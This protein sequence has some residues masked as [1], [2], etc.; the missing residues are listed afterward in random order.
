MP[1][2]E[3]ESSSELD[4]ASKLSSARSSRADVILSN[5]GPPLQIATESANACGGNLSNI[6][7][8]TSPARKSREQIRR[9]KLPGLEEL[10]D[11]NPSAAFQPDS[12]PLSPTTSDPASVSD[13]H[14]AQ[15]EADHGTEAAQAVAMEAFDLES[16]GTTMSSGSLSEEDPPEANP[17]GGGMSGEVQPIGSRKAA[18]GREAACLPEIARV[19]TLEQDMSAIA[20]P[21]AMSILTPTNDLTNKPAKPASNSSSADVA[22]S[23]HVRS[24]ESLERQ[25]SAG[26]SPIA[27][28]TAAGSSFETKTNQVSA[29][30][31]MPNETM[32]EGEPAKGSSSMSSVSSLAVLQEA[33]NMEV[34]PLALEPAEGLS[35]NDNIIDEENIPS[36]AFY[37]ASVPTSEHNSVLLEL[38]RTAGDDGE[39]HPEEL[40][41][42]LGFRG[43]LH[44]AKSGPA[45]DEDSEQ[46]AGGAEQQPDPVTIKDSQTAQIGRSN[47]FQRVSGHLTGQQHQGVEETRVS[48]FKIDFCDRHLLVKLVLAD[49]KRA[50]TKAS[51]LVVCVYLSSG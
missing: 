26:H 29:G 48:F 46:A 47:T 36:P 20:S 41:E 14:F 31:W 12:E 44:G 32:A 19:E 38:G 16:S 18:A 50:S 37:Q 25:S 7:K 35:P 4:Y 9:R 3:S 30:L 11:E 43:P 13:S 28:A 42:N 21:L 40:L 24:R 6:V 22:I 49:I 39:Q 17:E 33:A 1:L 27:E 34:N 23:G 5:P 15:E 51:I 2:E 45:Q 8:E 10:G